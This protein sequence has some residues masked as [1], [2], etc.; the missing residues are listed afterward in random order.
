MILNLLAGCRLDRWAQ[1]Q[2]KETT[3]SAAYGI[4][5]FVDG[6][7]GGRNQRNSWEDRKDAKKRQEEMDKLT[8][9]AEQRSAE[10]HS[11]RMRTYDRNDDDWNR[12]REDDNAFRKANQDAIDAA[13]AAADAERG[14]ANQPQRGSVSGATGGSAGGGSSAMGAFPA[15]AIAENL[16]LAGPQPA[17]GQ[18]PMQGQIAT[19]GQ[20]PAQGRQVSAAQGQ[21]PMQ[22]QIATQ[23]QPPAQGRQVSAAQGQPPMQG[24]IATQGQPPAQGRQVSAA[25]GQPPMQGQMAAQDPARNKR[26]HFPG[27]GDVLLNQNG[28]AY[29]E[30]TGREVTDPQALSIINQLAS[31]P[32][33]PP[34]RPAPPQEEM[35]AFERATMTQAPNYDHDYGESLGPDAMEVLRSSN[36]ALSVAGDYVQGGWDTLANGLNSGVNAVTGYVTGGAAPQIPMLGQEPEQQ[37]QPPG[38]QPM[39]AESPALSGLAPDPIAGNAAPGASTSISPAPITG[40][41]PTS[42]APGVKAAAD[43]AATTLA[44]TASPAIA[45]AAA[46]APSTPIPIGIRPADKVPPARRDAAAKSF[47]EHYMEVGAPMVL[48]EY[49]RRG[50]MQKAQEFQEFLA[51]EETKLGMESWAKAAFAATVGDMDT[52]ADEILNAYNRLD[53]FPDGTT[54]VKEKSGFTYGKDGNPSG[55]KLTFRDEATGDTWE[56]VYSDP[57][58]LIKMGITLLTPDKAFEHY[59]AQVAADQAAKAAAGEAAKKTSDEA[60]KTTAADKKERDNR[61]DT[62][63]K[64]IF[65]D[66]QD[67][68]GQSTMTWAD[69]KAQAEAVYPSARSPGPVQGPN[70]PFPVFRRPEG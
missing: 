48:E 11:R 64:A 13:K 21:P 65:E 37:A 5:A 34:E 43:V 44:D 18:P 35:G 1:A 53:Y 47:I 3:M 7:V 42:A 67:A 28:R 66:S 24:Q 49:L 41:A 39:G 54:V 33:T 20:P 40:N 55:A 30:G 69:A 14:G 63:T 22:G 9:N 10:D 15:Q 23:G 19:Q 32:D 16:G 2:L 6:F 68:M 17:Q 61:I 25:Q 56:Q 70:I 45:A 4:S 62:A 38:P 58:D 29:V 26:V 50:D 57:N 52:F 36:K 46:S 12:G 59:S 31:N 27:L 51:N 8:M 60:A